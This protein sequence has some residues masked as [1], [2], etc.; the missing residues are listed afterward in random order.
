M[1]R[2]LPRIRGERLVPTD[3]RDAAGVGMPLPRR[4]LRRPRAA[5]V[6]ER[7]GVLRGRRHERGRVGGRRRRAAAGDAARVARRGLH[8]G[9]GR[10]D[11]RARGRG[12]RRV[13]LELRRRRGGLR[14]L[15]RAAARRPPGRRV[16]AGPRRV[17]GRRRRSLRGRG[18]ER[19]RL[20][21]DVPVAPRRRRPRRGRPAHRRLR[22]L[23]AVPDG[24]VLA[25]GLAAL[26]VVLLL[27][28][29]GDGAPERRDG[30]DLR[31]RPAGPAADPLLRPRLR[32][33]RRRQRLQLRRGEGHG[34]LRAGALPERGS[35]DARRQRGLRL[36]RPLAAGVEPLDVGVGPAPLRPPLARPRPQGA[37]P[38]P[39]AEAPRAGLR[40]VRDGRRAPSRLRPGRRPRVRRRLRRDARHRP[41]WNDRSWVSSESRLEITKHRS[42]RPW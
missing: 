7:V 13:Q 40:G 25:R 12:P 14:E 4:G 27:E 37:A 34:R 32:G 30:R 10:G 6:W 1:R 18:R 15:R 41:A 17:L 16:V 31:R 3:V 5:P 38:G 42:C 2:P 8:A 24:D 26:Q 39:R 21:G 28:R 19:R 22:V 23:P 20:L 33:L 9:D 29:V 36:R 35:S 11:V